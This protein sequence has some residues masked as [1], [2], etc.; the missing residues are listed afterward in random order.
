MIFGLACVEA[1]L[2]G[3]KKT[4]L[5]GNENSHSSKLRDED[6]VTSNIRSTLHQLH[7]QAGDLSMFRGLGTLAA[8]TCTYGP[9]SMMIDWLSKFPLRWLHVSRLGP[10]VS[11]VFGQLVWAQVSAAWLHIVISK[12]QHKFWFRRL[13]EKW[14]EVV[15]ATWLSGVALGLVEEFVNWASALIPATPSSRPDILQSGIVEPVIHTTT[16]NIGFFFV[17]YRLMRYFLVSLT[18]PTLTA[19]L[20]VPVQATLHRIEASMLPEDEDTII[21]VDRSFGSEKTQGQHRQAQAITTQSAWQSISQATYWRLVRL[22]AKS[23]MILQGV[24]WCFW[25]L[26]VVQLALLFGLGPLWILLKISLD[27]RIGQ[28]DLDGLTPSAQQLMTGFLPNT[29]AFTVIS[30]A[31]MPTASLTGVVDGNIGEGIKL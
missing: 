27:I 16:T 2:P 6:F 21:P 14:T 15:A 30:K 9:V 1:R 22:N 4:D 13:P 11:R 26:V 18:K 31:P 24:T 23:W 28:D 12:P 20:V 17:L 10:L 7:S 5:L 25:A 8:V 29:T 19:L 3:R